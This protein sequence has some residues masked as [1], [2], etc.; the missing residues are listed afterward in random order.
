ME[1][2]EVLRV[3]SSNVE[4][5]KELA[6]QVLSLLAHFVG[7]CFDSGKSNAI[8]DVVNLHR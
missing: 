6:M 8:R 2:L 1:R 3:G 4:H 7:R 5:M